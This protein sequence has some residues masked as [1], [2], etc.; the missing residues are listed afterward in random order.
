MNDYTLYIK[1]H[2]EY[3]DYEETIEAPSKMVAVIK[4]YKALK[5]ELDLQFIEDNLL[6]EK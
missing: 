5:G 4:F 1:S 3:P 2:G 6:E